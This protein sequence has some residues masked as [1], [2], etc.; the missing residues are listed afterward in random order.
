MF[1]LAGSTPQGTYS[2]PVVATYKAGLLDRVHDLQCG[3]ANGTTLNV[4][5][6][7]GVSPTS[8]QFFSAAR[9]PRTARRIATFSVDAF[10]DG[11]LSV[12]SSGAQYVITDWQVVR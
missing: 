8:N 10:G 7:T 6:N 11:T 12:S 9:S 3:L 1:T 4:T 2:I 5:T